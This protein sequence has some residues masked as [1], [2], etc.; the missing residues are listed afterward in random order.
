MM[1]V[2]LMIIYLLKNNLNSYL[3]YKII[4]AIS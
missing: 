2:L 4:Q 1:T 3:P